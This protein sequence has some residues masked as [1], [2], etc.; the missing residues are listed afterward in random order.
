[1]IESV[2]VIELVAVSVAVNGLAAG[3]LQRDA[4]GVHA[5]V[6]GGEG[7][8]GGQASLA[9]AAREVDRAG[10][11]RIRVSRRVQSADDDIGY[12]PGSDRGRLDIDSQVRAG[13]N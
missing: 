7:V 6:A 9:V 12:I 11:G 2:P 3:S 4:E 8:V 1:M 10:V 13:G 5:A